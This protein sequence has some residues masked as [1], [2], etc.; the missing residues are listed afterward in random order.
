MVRAIGL[1]VG[2]KAAVAARKDGSLVVSKD[3][4]TAQL[5]AN[6]SVDVKGNVRLPKYV[7]PKHGGPF[8]IKLGTNEVTVA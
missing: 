7:L 4:G 2:D 1:D 6:Y 5:V 8:K 3:S